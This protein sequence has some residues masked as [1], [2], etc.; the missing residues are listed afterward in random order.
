[1]TKERAPEW[2]WNNKTEH[3]QRDVPAFITNSDYASV[4][5]DE[6][7]EGI[8]M[9]PCWFRCKLCGKVFGSERA[10]RD[11][12]QICMGKRETA[13]PRRRTSSPG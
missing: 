8:P 13:V 3:L 12:E 1:M 4:R 7:S 10:L 9:V 6:S 11:H 5:S 2:Y